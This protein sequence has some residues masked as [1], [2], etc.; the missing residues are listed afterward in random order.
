MK[1]TERQQR[2]AL[3]ATASV[4]AHALLAL[5][6]WRAS[7]LPSPFEARPAQP[8]S[9][10]IVLQETAPRKA[11]PATTAASP[12]LSAA[13]VK[14]AARAQDRARSHPAAIAQAAPAV[15]AV[16]AT[17]SAAAPKGGTS[18]EGSG[19]GSR[20]GGE[21]GVALVPWTEPWL[22][23][24]G[25]AAGP[26]PRGTRS[27]GAGTNLDKPGEALGIGPAEPDELP[28][29]TPIVPESAEAANRRVRG[30]IDG[31]ASA[32]KAQQRA[33]FA[34]VYWRK[35]REKL[36]KDFQVPYEVWTGGSKSG[37]RQLVAK[38]TD[39]HVKD[40]AAYGKSGNPFEGQA[41]A[42]GSHRSLAADVAAQ[43]LE[44]RGVLGSAMATEMLG[45]FVSTATNEQLVVRVLISQRD[46]GAVADVALADSSGNTAYDRLALKQARALLGAELKQLGPM[47]RE[48]RRS[49]WAFETDFHL[50]VGLG[51]GLDA[52]FVPRDCFTPGQKS[53]RSKVRLEAIY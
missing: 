42:P 13:P 11:P 8:Q 48:G 41:G 5:A 2:F 43:G 32:Y 23:A 16:P 45:R 29:A 7:T 20:S 52:Y 51:C 37:G 44:Q 39:Q 3:G 17:P 28:R 21:D 9:I 30:R 24:E 34:D 26:S 40:M 15:P 25:L 14:K 53:A 46:D 36:S 38:L 47:P 4:V 18:A 10:E 27:G 35:L 19:D 49:L 12:A 31:F 22:R 1:L 6:L 50:A 33:E